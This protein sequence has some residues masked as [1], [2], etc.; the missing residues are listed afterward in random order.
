MQVTPERRLAFVGLLVE[1]FCNKLG[2]EVEVLWVADERH[3]GLRLVYKGHLPLLVAMWLELLQL[4]P[5]VNALLL[6]RCNLVGN[7]D[8]L[9]LLF[10]QRVFALLKGPTSPLDLLLCR[11]QGRFE[12]KQFFDV[13]LRDRHDVLGTLGVKIHIG[14]DDL[15]FLLD[16]RL[17]RLKRVLFGV[18][19][20]G[21]ASLPRW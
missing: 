3:E 4:G 18:F 1:K 14:G 17:H 5:Q 7:L 16:P 12:L 15:I 9:R 19:E 13:R 6:E 20:E 21:S 10:F 2:C 11:Q 8:E